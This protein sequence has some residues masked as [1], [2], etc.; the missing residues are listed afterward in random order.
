MQRPAQARRPRWLRLEVSVPPQRAQT[1]KLQALQAPA[2]QAQARLRPARP[3]R[4]PT[5]RRYRPRLQPPSG[6]QM[7]ERPPRPPPWPA[8]PQQ[9]TGPERP[10]AVPAPSQRVAQRPPVLAQRP[11]QSAAEQSCQC[12]S[13]CAAATI[14]QPAAGANPA[15]PRSARPSA[16]AAARPRRVAPFQAP[17]QARRRRATARPGLS[18]SSSDTVPASGAAASGRK[19]KRITRWSRTSSNSNG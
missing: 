10:A 11:R 1:P 9:A 19:R 2:A 13:P 18:A 12:P 17:S 6:V 14:D 16:G 3:A 7:L 15:P 5:P 4:G 8:P